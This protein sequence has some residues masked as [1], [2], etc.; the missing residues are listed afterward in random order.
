VKPVKVKKNQGLLINPD[1]GVTITNSIIADVPGRE[2]C[3]FVLKNDKILKKARPSVKVF[4]IREA[5][6]LES[7]ITPLKTHFTPPVETGQPIFIPSERD[8]THVVGAVSGSTAKSPRVTMA[9][10]GYRM[11][12]N[13]IK[14]RSG[15]VEKE[16]VCIQIRDHRDFRLASEDVQRQRRCACEIVFNPAPILFGLKQPLVLLFKIIE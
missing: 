13:L 1:F 8:P 3:A 9:Y 2:V 5:A 10:N 16:Q 7:I 6:V 12:G 4:L 15:A 14:E 11:I